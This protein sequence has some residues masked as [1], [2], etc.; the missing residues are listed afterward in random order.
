MLITFFVKGSSQLSNLTNLNNI[1][2]KVVQKVKK[3][4]W[5]YVVAQHYGLDPHVVMDW[6]SDSILEALAALKVMGAIK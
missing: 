6:D 1:P 4:L 5:P 3:N 2:K